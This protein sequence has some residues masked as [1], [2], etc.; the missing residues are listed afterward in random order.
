MK[1]PLHASPLPFEAV[2]MEA[3]EALYN[4]DEGPLAGYLAGLAEGLSLLA[5]SIRQ[6]ERNERPIEEKQTPNGDAPKKASLP[7]QH[8]EEEWDASLDQF[9]RVLKEGDDELIASY[10]REASD[11]ISEVSRVLRPDKGVRD[12]KLEFKHARKGRSVDRREQA[13]KRRKILMDVRFKT[14]KFGKQGAAIADFDG[15]KGMSRATIFRAK[16][17]GK[18]TAQKTPKKTAKKTV[19]KTKKSHKKT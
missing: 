4:G 11:I 2:P 12:W 14:H 3:K 5:K 13:R 6:S 16:K 15:E 1:T 19:Q 10:L 17:A 7:N 9:E 18:K 8:E